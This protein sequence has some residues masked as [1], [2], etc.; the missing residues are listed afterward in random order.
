M[1]ICPKLNSL[2][3]EKNEGW[4]SMGEHNIIFRISQER[5]QMMTQNNVVWKVFVNNR[6]FAES[7]K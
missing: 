1:K 7:Q 3:V 4:E 2:G 5:D 6:E